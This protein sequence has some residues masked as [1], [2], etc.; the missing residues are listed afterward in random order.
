M[1]RTTPC[2]HPDSCLISSAIK[3][4]RYEANFPRLLESI[5]RW[6]GELAIFQQNLKV[7]VK[8]TSVFSE[9]FES[10]KSTSFLRMESFWSEIP[11]KGQK[12]KILIPFQTQDKALRDCSSLSIPARY[13]KAR[14]RCQK[15]PRRNV[16]E[17]WYIQQRIFYNLCLD[18]TNRMMPWV[19]KITGYYPTIIYSKSLCQFRLFHKKWWW[20]RNKI[21]AINSCISGSLEGYEPRVL[22]YLCVRSFRNSGCSCWNKL[23][24]KSTL[25]KIIC[26]AMI[27]SS[28]TILGTIDN[29][30]RWNSLKKAG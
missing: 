7:S 2:L 11:E 30:F 5:N 17:N 18:A 1:V 22:S 9:S 23:S 20:I 13:C 10:Q 27:F 4:W 21:L 19:P 14:S 15:R 24:I 16:R 29:N 3:E 12:K 8:R 26:S 25:H 6:E 28:P